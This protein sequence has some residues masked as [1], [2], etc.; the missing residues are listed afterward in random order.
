MIKIN[1]ID[2]YKSH[3]Y[4]HKLRNEND[5]F[6]DQSWTLSHP[7]LI[8]KSYETVFDYG[9]KKSALL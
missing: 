3:F 4:S 7:Y 5:I 9:K 2:H 1:S 8:S 6:K